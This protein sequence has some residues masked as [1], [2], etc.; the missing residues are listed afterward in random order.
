MSPF[1]FRKPA[2]GSFPHIRKEFISFNGI[3]SLTRM[4]TVE[5]LFQVIHLEAKDLKAPDYL[6]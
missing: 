6:T 1:S 2:S 4:S 3:V 5:G